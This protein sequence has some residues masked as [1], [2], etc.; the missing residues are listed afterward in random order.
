METEHYPHKVAAVY[1]S[2]GAAQAAQQALLQAGLGDIVIRQVGPN[3]VDADA[4]I[5]PEQK[6][7]RNRFIQ[8]ILA[9]GALGAAAGVAGAGASAALLPTLFVAAPVLGPLMVV[10]YAATLGGGAGAVK[11]FKI[12]EGILAGVVEDAAKDGLCSL[13]VHAPDAETNAR[14]EQILEQTLAEETLTA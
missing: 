12:K 10:G 2:A 1:S 3:T 13:I 7:T 5:E 11:A 4:R 8:D 6:Q 14:V 9:G